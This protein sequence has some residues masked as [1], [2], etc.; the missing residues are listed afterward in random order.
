M[1]S[2]YHK[3]GVTMACVAIVLQCCVKHFNSTDVYLATICIDCPT[4]DTP[5]LFEVL[6]CNVWAGQV[7]IK[8]ELVT[9]LKSPSSNSNA[10]SCLIGNTPDCYL[11]ITACMYSV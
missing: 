4:H 5:V 3:P 8:T 10:S 11:V 6:Y 9:C 1:L 2:G 7:W